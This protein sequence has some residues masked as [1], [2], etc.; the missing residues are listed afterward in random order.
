MKTS[1]KLL[2]ILI[3]LLL[4]NCTSEKNSPTD[5]HPGSGSVKAGRNNKPE[6]KKD[7]SKIDSASMSN[8]KAH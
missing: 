6:E 3:T 1:I 2:S 8:T 7:T 4:T 5:S